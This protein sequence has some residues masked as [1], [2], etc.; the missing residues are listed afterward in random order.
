MNDEFIRRFFGGSGGFGASSHH[1]NDPFMNM[2]S[3]F[4]RMFEEMDQMMSR[5][6][7]GNFNMI[8][9]PNESIDLPGEDDSI[10]KNE[11]IRDKFLKSSSNKKTNEI[12]PS[13]RQPSFVSKI[14][15]LLKT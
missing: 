14:I 3:E 2:H 15:Y 9:Q 7:Y 6:H 10:N 13:Y 5:F 1:S 11:S 8:D 4:Q 12:V